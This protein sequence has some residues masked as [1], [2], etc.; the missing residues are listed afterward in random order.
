MSVG[1]QK[2]VT[3]TSSGELGSDVEEISQVF[4]L[5]NRFIGDFLHSG[6]SS[7]LHFPLEKFCGFINKY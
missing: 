7:A 3:S 2:S 5:A 1:G 4:G 6:E